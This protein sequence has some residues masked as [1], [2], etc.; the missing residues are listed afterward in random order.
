MVDT[1]IFYTEMENINGPAFFPIE[2]AG[3]LLLEG[4][5]IKEYLQRQTSNNLDLLKEGIAVPN[6][7]PNPKGR[8]LDFFI[9]VLW[10]NGIALITPSGQ[11][12]GIKAYFEQRIFFN[13]D[14][15]F[16]D[17]SDQWAQFIILDLEHE[18]KI[19]PLLSIDHMPSPNEILNV[20]VNNKDAFILGSNDQGKF[21]SYLLIIPS[22]EAKGMQNELVEAGITQLSPFAYEQFRIANGIPGPV[23]FSAAYT[24]FE[25]GL[26]DFV[27]NSKGCYTGQEVLARQVNFDK[28]SKTRALIHSESHLS[29]GAKIL[30]DGQ[31]VGEISSV[32]NKN[33]EP[34]IALAII[35]KNKA[36]PGGEIVISHDDEQ[37]SGVIARIFD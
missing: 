8:V 34:A 14:V 27:S 29:Q 18:N 2:N 10:K 23:E 32:L 26:K 30:M 24:P 36:V 11:A 13:D 7:L 21:N 12:I 22:S 15:R 6:I 4:S 33:G 37:V 3:L 9:N 16:S 31:M 1:K 28:I 20:S 35:K 19:I 25:L 5:S 17:E